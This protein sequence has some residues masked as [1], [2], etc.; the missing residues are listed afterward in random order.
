MPIKSR[1][2][3]SVFTAGALLVAAGGAQANPVLQ[4]ASS[5][6]GFSSQ[7]S[8]TSWS[9]QQALGAPNTPSYGDIPTAW[10]PLP[11]N[12]SLEWL[13]V[14]FG[15][16][17]YATGATIRESSGNGFVYQ[18]DLI[19]TLGHLHTVWSGA[20]NSAPGA[21]V[22]FTLAWAPTSY[23][24]SGLKVYTNT[25]HNSSSWEE[26]DAIQLAGS[27]TSANVPEPGTM[28]LL[29]MGLFAFAAARRKPGHR[30]SF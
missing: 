3:A 22:D 20:D 25:D 27:T 13:S 15:T 10:A 19:D 1:F 24:V 26:I 18:V 8:T 5:V 16:A 6:I 7:Y 12:G 9:A 17:V 14:G 28:V 4:Y 30:K 21:L 2:L 29:G 11:R 23:L